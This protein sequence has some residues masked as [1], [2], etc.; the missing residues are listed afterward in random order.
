MHGKRKG[1]AGAPR[2]DLYKIYNGGFTY[3]REIPREDFAGA[4]QE[5]V[6]GT[7][8]V[9][10]AKGAATTMGGVFCCRSVQR[11]PRESLVRKGRDGAQTGV[12]NLHLSRSESKSTFHVIEEQ[13]SLAEPTRLQL[14]SLTTLSNKALVKKS[15]R[16]RQTE[17]MTK[18]RSTRWQNKLG[19]LRRPASIFD[20]RLKLALIEGDSAGNALDSALS[21][22]HVKPRQFTQDIAGIH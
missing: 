20:I 18:D 9:S 15:V 12:Y 4:V 21:R 6:H 10:A 3:S 7:Y 17:G 8:I 22:V 16:H 13:Q 11:R 5:I 19:T 14:D 1:E 2:L